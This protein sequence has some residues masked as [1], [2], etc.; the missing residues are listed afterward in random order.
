VAAVSPSASGSRSHAR[1]PA[2]SLGDS[3]RRCQAK[4]VC[5]S[6]VPNCPS[7]MHI[8]PRPRCPIDPH[9]HMHARERCRSVRLGRPTR[10][11]RDR[12]SQS[13]IVA[14]SEDHE[15]SA[16]V[17]ATYPVAASTLARAAAW[18]A[19][20]GGRVRA[21]AAFTQSR[22]LTSKAV[23]PD[24]AWHGAPSHIPWFTLIMRSICRTYEVG[25]RCHCS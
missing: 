24:L 5:L 20:A 4:P 14:S 8:P 1:C 19:P 12:R 13:Y 15:T 9:P 25:C 3:A 22:A 11:P 7:I 6:L 23:V 2:V 21:C 18:S 10:S 16:C 17:L